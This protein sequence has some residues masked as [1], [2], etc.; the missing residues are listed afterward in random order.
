MT[1]GNSLEYLH[2][3]NN[4]KFI[5]ID[6]SIQINTIIFEQNNFTGR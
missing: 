5:G 6:L 3:Q 2:H 1:T 4:Y